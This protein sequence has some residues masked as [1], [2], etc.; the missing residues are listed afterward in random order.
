MSA[1]ARPMRRMM[2]MRA[3]GRV[4][5]RLGHNDW[6]TFWVVLDHPALPLTNNEAERALPHWGKSPAHQHRYAHRPCRVVRGT[7]FGEFMFVES[8]V[9]HGSNVSN[10]PAVTRCDSTEISHETRRILPDPI[11]LPLGVKSRDP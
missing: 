5:Q 8:V 3:L 11:D 1:R 4:T 10:W 2:K 6:D 9:P 7:Q